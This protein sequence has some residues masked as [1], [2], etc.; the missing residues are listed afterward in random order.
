MSRPAGVERAVQGALQL[1]ATGV[2]SDVFTDDVTGWTPL[3]EVHGR[4]QLR[5]QVTDWR[6][7]M[8]DIDL[9]VDGIA[10]DGATAM[11]RWRL[12]ARHTGVVLVN[13]DLLYEPSGQEV[14][15]AVT[16]EFGFRDERICWFRHDYDLDDL[17]R[18]LRAADLG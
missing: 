3:G 18:Q 2:E 7:G 16:S 5:D 9:V 14:T 15:V 6:D 4:D 13:E 12:S 11:A 1:M 17:L 10:V 8:T